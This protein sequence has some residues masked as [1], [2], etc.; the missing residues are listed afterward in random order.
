MATRSSAIDRTTGSRTGL[1]ILAISAAL[2]AIFVFGWLLGTNSGPA[3]ESS[4]QYPQAETPRERYAIKVEIDPSFYSF[5]GEFD[6][7]T[8]TASVA[9]LR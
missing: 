9:G 6:S 1:G 7:R 2:I 4:I 3:I 8:E 5:Y